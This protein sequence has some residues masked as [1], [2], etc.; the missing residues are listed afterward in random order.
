[1]SIW[2]TPRECRSQS[3]TVDNHISLQVSYN[4]EYIILYLHI[5][6]PG[7]PSVP[8]FG[9]LWLLLG[10][11]L[12]EIDSNCFPGIYIYIYDIYTYIYILYTYRSHSVM[13]LNFALVFLDSAQ[14]LSPFQNISPTAQFG[15]NLLYPASA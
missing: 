15:R 4:T 6:I 11:T 7:K 9:R 3:S 5:Y 2:S 8:F 1:M 12:M 14:H 10:V 13:I